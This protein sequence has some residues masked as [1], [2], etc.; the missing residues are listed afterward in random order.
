MEI[1][2]GY[3]Y[4][5]K[6]DYFDKAQDNKL[7][8]NKEN[9]NFRP[10]FFCIEDKKTSLLWVVPMSSKIEKYE[11]LQKKQIEKYGHCLTIVIGE[12]DNRKSAF[13][14]Q[15]MFPITKEYLD[16]I[17]TRN[18]NPV[19]V[20]FSLTKQVSQNMQKIK[21]LEARGKKVVF[22]NI[23]RLENLM[24]SEIKEVELNMQIDKTSIID[25]VN[26]A[27]EKAEEINNSAHAISK[28]NIR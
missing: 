5:I 16:H 18:G 4:H 20:K 9:G 21:Q 12:Y 25:R 17:H 14:L 6:E 27:K 22:P 24:L 26:I 11:L 1:Q 8:Q 15:N 19:P 23:K 2:P 13:L 10:T 28:D 3:V 7:M